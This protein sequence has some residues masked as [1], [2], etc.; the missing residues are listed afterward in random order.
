MPDRPQ[1]PGRERNVVFHENTFFS[2][3]H[4]GYRETTSLIVQML[5][6]KKHIFKNMSIK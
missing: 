6:Y 1:L 2:W 5:R 4:G 3:K